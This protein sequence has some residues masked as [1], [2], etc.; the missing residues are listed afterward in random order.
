MIQISN[1][2]LRTPLA[3]AKNLPELAEA[4][5]QITE[6]QLK[7][8]RSEFSRWRRQMLLPALLL[9]ASLAVV[10]SGV[11]LFLLG[12]A[13][14]AAELMTISLASSLLVVAFISGL[15]GSVVAILAWLWIRSLRSPLRYLQCQALQDVL[16]LKSRL[17]R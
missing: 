5:S 7:L 15:L 13:I 16:W 10:F 9:I 8:L 4:A 14:V 3:T 1:S 2:D 17:A 6:V 12:V 11:P